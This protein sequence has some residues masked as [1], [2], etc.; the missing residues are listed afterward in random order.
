VGTASAEPSP[1]AT[2]EPTPGPTAAATPEAT[3]DPTPAP[4]R[5]PTPPP[6]PTPTPTPWDDP[7]LATVGS[8]WTT[9]PLEGFT[10]RLEIFS[11]CLREKPNPYN[12]EPYAEIGFRIS[13]DGDVPIGK[14]TG[15]FGDGD[16]ELGH[17]SGLPLPNSSSY[18]VVM[19]LLPRHTF[20]I[21][22]AFYE[23][24]PVATEASDDG[25]LL[26]E[27]DGMFSVDPH[28]PC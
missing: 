18:D 8:A 27:I 24:D 11:E 20:D 10:G 12:G 6:D 22:F 4:T 26:T 2:T 16:N 5:P 7:N 17:G 14:I 3:P 9:T 23:P 25:R 19:T 21:D 13:W 28:D 15:D 1:A